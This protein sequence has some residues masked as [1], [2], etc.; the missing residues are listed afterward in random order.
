MYKEGAMKTRK[1]YIEVLAGKIKEWEDKVDY[2]RKR[3]DTAT[4]DAREKLREEISDLKTVIEKAQGLLTEAHENTGEAW[5]RV[6]SEIDRLLARVKD[7][8]KKA[9]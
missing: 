1:E 4:L 8:M 6:R 5:D 3:V 9:A 7:I 2:L